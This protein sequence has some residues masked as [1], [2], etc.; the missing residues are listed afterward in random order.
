MNSELKSNLAKRVTW[1]RGLYMLLFIVIFHV[2]EVVVGAVVLLQFLFTLLTGQTNAR[3][4]RFGNSLS[5]YVYQILSFLM[6]NTEQMPFPFSEWP[7]AEVTSEQ[8]SQ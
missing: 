3:L 8:D 2:S 7:T 4:L 5:R 6:F 1:L